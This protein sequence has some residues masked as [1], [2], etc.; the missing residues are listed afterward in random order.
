MK[1]LP[2]DDKQPLEEDIPIKTADEKPQMPK[3]N[4]LL[5]QLEIAEETT[6]V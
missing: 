2:F 3:D 5:E 1:V 6:Y 4:Q